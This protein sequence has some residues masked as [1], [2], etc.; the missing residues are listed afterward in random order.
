ML[1]CLCVH[2]P[3]LYH[4]C[5]LMYFMHIYLPEFPHIRQNYSSSRLPVHLHLQKTGVMHSSHLCCNIWKN[6]YKIVL[7]MLVY[8]FVQKIMPYACSL[9]AIGASARIPYALITPASC[10]LNFSTIKL[11]LARIFVHTCTWINHV[12][13]VQLSKNATETKWT[14]TQHTVHWTLIP[15]CKCILQLL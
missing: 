7:C 8:N 10:R 1:L 5:V 2:F 4:L 6:I 12:S 13:R 9:H 15:L 14:L 3:L 11:H